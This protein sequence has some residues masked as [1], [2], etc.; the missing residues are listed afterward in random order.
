MFNEEWELLTEPQLL[1]PAPLLNLSGMATKNDEYLEKRTGLND[2]FAVELGQQ[3]V[4]DVADEAVG[5][6][7]TPPAPPESAR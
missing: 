1:E 6:V 2:T 3:D 7:R 5:D 4:T